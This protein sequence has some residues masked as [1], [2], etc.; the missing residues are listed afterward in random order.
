MVCKL[1]EMGADPAIPTNRRFTAIHIASEV[2]DTRI[3]DVLLGATKESELN[4]KTTDGITPLMCA[5]ASG[6][7]DNVNLLQEKGADLW[8]TDPTNVNSFDM[9]ARAG[10]VELLKCVIEQWKK[11][12]KI[13]EKARTMLAIHVACAYSQ[14]EVVKLFMQNRVPPNVICN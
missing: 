11:N 12:V 10:Q 8:E 7:M 1:L 6:F 3:L 2:K 9:M 14:I 5:S 4:A 13:P